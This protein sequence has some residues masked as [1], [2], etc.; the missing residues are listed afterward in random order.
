MT[1]NPGRFATRPGDIDHAGVELL[2]WFE[3][4]RG[5]P[6]IG[7]V[8]RWKLTKGERDGANE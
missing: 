5:L 2:V 8:I 4:V 1:M 7:K 6:L 3:K